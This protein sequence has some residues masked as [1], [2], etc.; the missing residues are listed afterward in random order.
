MF[1]GDEVANKL[2]KRRPVNDEELRLLYYL[3]TPRDDGGL[4]YE[5]YDQIPYRDV[6]GMRK[7]QRIRRLRSLLTCISVTK[8]WKERLHVQNIRKIIKNEFKD[9]AYEAMEMYDG[10]ESD[11]NESDE[12]TDL[13]PDEA[14]VAELR[15]RIR[16]E[17]ELRCRIREECEKEYGS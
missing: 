8:R 3:A 9:S 15:C 12:T 17:Y 5:D 1:T 7:S 10:N 2:A 14:A 16:D 11:G 13:F 4:V 6:K